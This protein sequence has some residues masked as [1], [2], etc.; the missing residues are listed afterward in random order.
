MVKKM[1]SKVTRDTHGSGRESMDM[2]LSE[3]A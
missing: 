2:I 3:N 1:M